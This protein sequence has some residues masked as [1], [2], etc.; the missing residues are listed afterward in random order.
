MPLNLQLSNA[1]VNAEADAHSALLNNGYLRIY[2]G[3][4]PV[5]ADAALS[6]QTL[7]ATLRFAVTAFG[8]AAAGVAVANAIAS[9]TNAAAAG[10]ASW[11]RTLKA[12]GTTAVSDG[13]VGTSGANLNLNSVNIT[14]G[15]QVDCSSFAFTQPKS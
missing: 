15:A 6:T 10:T 4:Q 8:A 2:D 7:L 1:A 12:D 3:T 9:D 5:S 13:S 11:Y 14:V